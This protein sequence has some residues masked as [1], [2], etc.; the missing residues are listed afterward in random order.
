MIKRKEKTGHSKEIIEN[1]HKTAD[2]DYKRLSLPD[3][4]IIDEIDRLL[5]KLSEDGRDYWGTYYS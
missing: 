5:K 4:K 3:Q 1:Y 2:D